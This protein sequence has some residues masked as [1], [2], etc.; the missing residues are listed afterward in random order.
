MAVT[1]SVHYEK[2]LI[3]VNACV[4]IIA[5][6]P[7]IIELLQ[8]NVEFRRWSLFCLKK[9][10]AERQPIESHARDAI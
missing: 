8:L 6:N 7:M 4:R 5:C 3:H 1:I 2:D 9:G 10:R